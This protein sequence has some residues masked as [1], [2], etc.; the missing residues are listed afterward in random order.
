[1]MRRRKYIPNHIND[2]EEK[3]SLYA[4]KKMQKIICKDLKSM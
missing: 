2:V 1:M 4:T 3:R